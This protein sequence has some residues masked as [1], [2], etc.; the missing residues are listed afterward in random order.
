MPLDLLE[1]ALEHHRAGRL[2]EAEAGYRRLME[3]KPESPDGPQWLGVLLL[4]AGQAAAALPLLERAAGM[5]PEDPAF[6]FNL[7]QAYLAAGRME[8]A[9]PAFERATSLEPGNARGWLGLGNA[10]IGRQR[11]EDAI[12]AVEALR[13]ARDTGLDSGELYRRLATALLAIGNADEAIVAANTALEKAGSAADL[14]APTHYRLALAY[15]LKRDSKAVRRNLLKALEN[16]AQMAEGWYALALLDLEESKPAQAVSL[17]RRAVA[18]DPGF[19]QAHLVLS[20]LLE[21]LGRHTDS[22][23]ALHQAERAAH[24]KIGREEPRK[25]SVEASVEEMEKRLTPD[26]SSLELHYALAALTNVLPPSAVPEAAVAG[27]FDKY[28]ATF[29]EHLREKLH[30][31]APEL[32]DAALGGES[33]GDVA[34]I[35]CGTG[36]AGVLLRPKAKTLVGVDLSSG[37]VEQAKRRGIYDRTEVGE[38][39]DFLRGTPRAFDTIVAA[40]VLLYLGDLGPTFEAAAKSVRP[41]GRFAFTLEAGG[42]ERYDLQIKT[43]RYRHSKAYVQK[44][45]GMY[46]FAEEKLDA[47]ALRQ[48]AGKPVVGWLVVLRMP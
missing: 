33:L 16:D 5:R 17:L 35:G 41:G 27:L 40:D 12:R 38:L 21:K 39:V 46:G 7:G 44:L 42:G 25:K 30:Y 45:A 2:R 48:E 4:Q 14:L 36:L 34:D 15:R 29:D 47:V 32:L 10:L 43:R 8:E 28:A 11:P 6:A 19:V 26:K 24:G 20:N 3:E 22:K 23:V 18:A 37:M 1:I 13:R 31:Q 9:V